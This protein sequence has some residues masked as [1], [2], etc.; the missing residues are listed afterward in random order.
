MPHLYSGSMTEL[1]QTL[2]VRMLRLV[3]K[4]AVHNEFGLPNLRRGVA[5]IKTR[6]VA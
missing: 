2:Q 3:F 6:T 1:G 4:A 5:G